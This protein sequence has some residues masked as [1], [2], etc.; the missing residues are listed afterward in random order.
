[1][2]F[3]FT[4]LSLPVSAARFSVTSLVKR[5]YETNII[6]GVQSMGKLHFKHSNVSL[7]GIISRALFTMTVFYRRVVPGN[8]AAH[9][10]TKQLFVLGG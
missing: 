9:P 8:E 7:L 2:Y 10:L 4:Q 5:V 1:M 6:C 3:Y